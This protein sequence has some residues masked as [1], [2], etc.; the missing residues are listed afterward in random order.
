M[1]LADCRAPGMEEELSASIARFSVEPGGDACAD[2]NA[3]TAS[4]AIIILTPPPRP[5]SQSSSAQSPLDKAWTVAR[6]QLASGRRVRLIAHGVTVRAEW[7]DWVDGTPNLILTELGAY[8][9]GSPSL[10]TRPLAHAVRGWLDS[11]FAGILPGTSLYGSAAARWMHDWFEAET[12]L[13]GLAAA[14]P[15]ATYLATEADWFGLS[16]LVDTPAAKDAAPARAAWRLRVLGRCAYQMARGA[17]GQIRSYFR[18]APTRERLRV[19]RKQGADLAPRHWAAL[20]GDWQRI[21]HHVVS[22]FVEPALAAGKPAGILVT[23]SLSPVRREANALAGASAI[24]PLAGLG[25]LPDQPGIVVEQAV[26]PETLAQ[27][28]R[29]LIE[30]TVHTARVAWRLSRQ[31]HIVLGDRRYDLGREL[32]GVAALAAT[33]L[34]QALA[35]RHAVQRLLSRRDFSA[36]RV[37]FS[38]VGLAETE[39][40]NHLLRAAGAITVDYMHGAGGDGWFGMAE[41]HCTYTAVWT[42]TDARLARELGQVPIIAGMAEEAPILERAGGITQNI[43]LLS[44]Y[45]HQDWATSAFPLA[46]FQTEVLA[47]AQL[48]EARFP[49]RFRFRWRPHPADAVDRVEQ[50]AAA[51]SGLELSRGGPIQPDIDWADI[52][53][54]NV[55]TTVPLALRSGLP[56]FVHAPPQYLGLPDVMAIDPMRRF[57]HAAEVVEPFAACVALLDRDDP[58]ACEPERS[59]S[60]ALLGSG[61]T[62]PP[63]LFDVLESVG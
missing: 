3:G 6:A 29:L 17:L 52:V 5:S 21:N 34:L 57:F 10:V 25:N 37:V 38:T 53:I 30:G 63:N 51:N 23:T 59:A 47:T 16:L 56:V 20:V 62:Q 40:T 50:A 33:D 19:L 14:H 39:M 48:I 54:S 60:H 45:L 28:I 7:P 42:E 44:S 15:G 58:G 18:A 61:N 49:G 55:S 31:R 46:P 36:T 27:L 22:R 43:L 1:N 2:A 35:S 13:Q 8:R 32:P 41:S 24:D 9:I 26:G 4:P 12:Y 11:L